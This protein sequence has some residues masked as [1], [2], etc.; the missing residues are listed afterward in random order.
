MLDTLKK[1]TKEF[2]APRASVMELNRSSF[3]DPS[4]F[5]APTIQLTN[6][7][8]NSNFNS[9][10]SSIIKIN[11]PERDRERDNSLTKDFEITTAKSDIDP[12]LPS[13]GIVKQSIKNFEFG[14]PVSMNSSEIPRRISAYPPVKFE[15]YSRKVLRSYFDVELLDELEEIERFEAERVFLFEFILHIEG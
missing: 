4:F 13:P 15:V 12:T 11:T 14:S 9:Q 7:S 2:S 3:L 10:R 8:S 6:P 5:I 1:H